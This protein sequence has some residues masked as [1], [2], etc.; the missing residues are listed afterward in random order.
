MNR[1]VLNGNPHIKRIR[2]VIARTEL[3]KQSSREEIASGRALA[4]TMELRGEFCA[5][6]VQTFDDGRRCEEFWGVRH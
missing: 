6:N 5:E 3:T 4:M 2:N 1:W